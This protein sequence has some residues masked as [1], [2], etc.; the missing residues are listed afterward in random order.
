MASFCDF[1]QLFTIFN[2]FWK[3]LEKIFAESRLLGSRRSKL[4]SLAQYRRRPT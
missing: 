3:I 1:L 4:G 2:L